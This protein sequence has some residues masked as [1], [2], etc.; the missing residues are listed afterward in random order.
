MQVKHDDSKYCPSCEEKLKQ[1][2]PY[3]KEWFHD[4]KVDHPNIHIAWAYRGK[5]DQ[6]K[7]FNEGKTHAHYPNSK[8]NVCD[9]DGKPCAEALDLFQLINGQAVFDRLFYATLAAKC[10]KELMDVC[11]GG[12]FKSL[13]DYDHFQYHEKS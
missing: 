5:E 6:E 11:W 10:A 7:L 9:K 2:H 13:G 4:R 12:N 3:L 1:C 8:H